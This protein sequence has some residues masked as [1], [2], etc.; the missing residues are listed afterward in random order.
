MEQSPFE[1]NWFAAS[2]EIPPL[3]NQKVYYS[4]HKVL[5][6]SLYPESAQSNPYPHIL[7]L[8]DPS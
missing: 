8:E 2:Q 1:A 3:L 7:L 4:I 5:V 6:T